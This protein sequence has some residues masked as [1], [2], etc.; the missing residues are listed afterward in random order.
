M[1][2]FGNRRVHPL[3]ENN[4]VIVC[5]RYGCEFRWVPVVLLQKHRR[6]IMTHLRTYPRTKCKLTHLNLCM[7]MYK[8]ILSDLKHSNRFGPKVARLF[9]FIEDIRGSKD[10]SISWSEVR[11]HCGIDQ[12]SG[13]RKF[14]LPQM[15]A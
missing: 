11:T 1:R 7:C 6:L 2:Y 8:H 10:N 14:N 4:F 9:N 3:G 5:N 13:S 15:T 12:F